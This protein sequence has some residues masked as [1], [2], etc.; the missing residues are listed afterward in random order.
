[1]LYGQ[2]PYDA[3]NVEDLLTQIYE[4]GP[5]FYKKKISRKL[6]E[7]IK[8]MLDPGSSS[9]ISH[10]DLFDLVIDDPNY[11]SSLL[12]ADASSPVNTNFKPRPSEG[13]LV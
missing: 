13:G 11:P 8:S 3:T 4:K 6:E 10:S 7:L 2:V 1:M 9:R 12:D 5:Q